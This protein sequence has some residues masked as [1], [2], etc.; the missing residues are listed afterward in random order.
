MKKL[1]LSFVLLMFLPVI[2]LSQMCNTT[3]TNMGSLTITN[4]FQNVT[5]AS[6]AKRYWTFNAIAGCTYDFS[7]CSS[8]FTNDTYLRLYSGTNPTSAIIQTQNDDNGIFCAGNK[9]SL[10]WVCTTSGTYSILVTNYICA[11]LSASTI[12]SYRRSCPTTTPI[13]DNCSNAIN[14]LS[15]P[16]TSPITSNNGATNDVPTS[17]SNCGTQGTNIW[18]K[19]TGN[20]NEYIA[21]TCNTSTNFD[22]EI[23]VY[24]GLCGALNSMVEVVCNDDDISCSINNLNSKVNWCSVL[25]V[26]YYISVGNY[27]SS[28][29]YGN[30]RLNVTQQANCV[31]LP[32]E[33]LSFVG[34]NNNSYNILTWVTASESNNDYFTLERSEDGIIWDIIHIEDGVGFSTQITSYSYNDYNFPPNNINYYRLRQTDYDGY[35]EIFD[36]ITINN[37][38][39]DSK[40]YLVKKFTIDGREITNDYRGLY[41][42]LY[43]DGT[44]KRVYK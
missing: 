36:I 7:T 33:L 26:T 12:L 21:T 17:V 18:Y 9:A 31:A 32:I 38:N 13:N 4:T 22:T 27:S 30:F 41:M 8:V 10:S 19:V 39:N 3:P 11:N 1:I 25:G 44:I 23:R 24:T 28:N 37:L 16:Y 6:G 2:S 42:E 40:K 29:V 14:I 15:L 34:E 5:N 20:G 43:S 35:F